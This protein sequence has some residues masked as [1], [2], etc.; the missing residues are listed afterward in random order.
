MNDQQL[1]VDRIVA[2]AIEI[3]QSPAATKFVAVAFDGFTNQLTIT[4]ISR[5]DYRRKDSRAIDLHEPGEP[6]IA[7][8]RVNRLLREQLTNLQAMHSKSTIPQQRRFS[9]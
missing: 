6:E 7:R 8:E 5:T 2:L 1:L 3:S 4:H 9:I